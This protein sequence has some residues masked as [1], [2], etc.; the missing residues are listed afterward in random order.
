MRKESLSILRSPKTHEHLQLKL[1]NGKE[2]LAS[3]KSAERFIIKDGI[4]LFL[5]DDDI[6]GLNK[7]YQKMYDRMAPFYDLYEKIL[8][9]FMRVD[10]G[11]IRGQ[12]LNELEIKDGSSV[13]EVSMG[14]GL[15]FKFL[16]GTANYYGVDIS[17]KMLKKCQ[18]NLKKWKMDAE[19]FRC[20]AENLPFGDESF[21]VVFHV[22]GI[23]FFNDKTRAIK[24][25]V[26]VAKPGTKFVIVDETEKHTKT[27]Y[28]KTPLM[29]KFYKN[30]GENLSVPVASVPAGMLDVQVKNVW[31]GRFYCLTFRKP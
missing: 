24:E 8:T 5:S 11:K 3:E 20:E 13:L 6:S 17:W 14:T 4:P 21:D 31:G 9:M 28:E 27:V 1:E 22:G 29:D 25:M 23:N 15:N 18:K 2:V 19:L 26:R 7:K 30:T 10:Q 16:P 12:F